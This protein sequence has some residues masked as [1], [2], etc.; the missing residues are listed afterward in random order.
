MKSSFRELQIGE[1]MPQIQIISQIKQKEDNSNKKQAK[2]QSQNQQNTKYFVNTEHQSYSKDI[3][4]VSRI[5]VK[6][7]Q[8]PTQI[9]DLRSGLNQSIKTSSK[10]TN[11]N[12]YSQNNQQNKQ[13]QEREKQSKKFQQSQKEQ[14][15]IL[16]RKKSSLKIQEQVQEDS[17]SQHTQNSSST[18]KLVQRFNSE[19]MTNN[20]EQPHSDVQQANS[21]TITNISNYNQQ[22]LEEE[23]EDDDEPD[24]GKKI[25]EEQKSGKRWKKRTTQSLVKNANRFYFQK[26]IKYLK[27]QFDLQ[28]NQNQNLA[29]NQNLDIRTIIQE[30]YQQAKIKPQSINLKFFRLCCMKLNNKNLEQINQK[31]D[32]Q[33]LHQTVFKNLWENQKIEKINAIKQELTIQISQYLKIFDFDKE[34]QEHSIQKQIEIQKRYRDWKDKI[35]INLNKLNAGQFNQDVLNEKLKSLQTQYNKY[36]ENYDVNS[37]TT[38]IEDS[39]AKSVKQYQA[40]SSFQIFEDADLPNVAENFREK[41][42]SQIFSDNTGT[43]LLSVIWWIL[44]FIIVLALYV[45]C[46]YSIFFK[47]QQRKKI[48]RQ[49]KFIIAGILFLLLSLITWQAI[50]QFNNE[51]D[52]SFDQTITN[53]DCTLLYNGIIFI[54]NEKKNQ[55]EWSGVSDYNTN[56]EALNDFYSKKITQSPYK[57]LDN[58][59]YNEIYG[60]LETQTENA[61]SLLT[62]NI[63]L[64]N[65]DP[66]ATTKP[67]IDSEYLLNLQKSV[68]PWLTIVSNYT[69]S[70]KTDG[71]QLGVIYTGLN[72]MLTN[73]DKILKEI[74]SAKAKVVQYTNSLVG[75]VSEFHQQLLQQKEEKQGLV[76]FV[77]WFFLISKL[78]VVFSGL[79]GFCLLMFVKG[80]DKIKIRIFGGNLM[81]FSWCYGIFFF[82][83]YIVVCVLGVYFLGVSIQTGY[84]QPL[85]ALENDSSFASKMWPG[86]KNQ[87]LKDILGEC[88]FGKDKN[89]GNV[90]TTLDTNNL[91]KEAQNVQKNMQI[92]TPYS[93]NLTVP[94]SA[95]INAFNT[96]KTNCN[97]ITSDFSKAIDSNGKN[98]TADVNAFNLWSDYNIKGSQQAGTGKCKVS[99]DQYTFTSCPANYTQYNNT[100]QLT[101]FSQKL[102]FVVNSEFPENLENIRYTDK[103]F[104]TCSTL[105]PQVFGEDS[106]SGVLQDYAH[107]FL[108]YTRDVE[109]KIVKN[110]PKINGIFNITTQ[111]QASNQARLS[112]KNITQAGAKS[113]ASD[114]ITPLNNMQNDLSCKFIRENL[115][116][117]T[118]NEVCYQAQNQIYSEYRSWI[119]FS[120]L[121]GLYLIAITFAAYQFFRLSTTVIV[122]K[123]DLNYMENSFASMEN[124]QYRVDTNQLQQQGE[125][126]QQQQQQQE[127]EIQQQHHQEENNYPQYVEQHD[128]QE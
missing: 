21:I 120:V 63:T 43:I 7:E 17:F 58:S 100:K 9:E 127:I 45:F 4:G 81:H 67:L 16:Q 125:I 88:A 50:V 82:L 108:I 111:V 54:K 116:E 56:L 42:Y 23:E 68:E 35:N 55:K 15:Q 20:L 40:V 62:K 41:N 70:L 105:K 34:I 47:R 102:C 106:V 115:I 96:H 99:Q 109:N 53:V 74:S 126:M 22:N 83:I 104:K 36:C 76:A 12:N 86:N 78:L 110:C 19:N 101:D 29:E 65:P 6:C 59:T 72:K 75:Q 3:N 90:F 10:N 92:Y 95:Q 124:S 8:E 30:T 114:Y 28:Q 66:S 91:L 57:E 61:K 113:F 37:R 118:R 5:Q 27:E 44:L 122:F 48:T 93:K 71:Q 51:T 2:I 80:E 73:K 69:D 87:E 52:E 94:T 39:T 117:P 11:L 31:K 46:I 98:A 84:C 85:S 103:A 24:K 119:L 89:L 33:I 97:A 26:I 107:N 123:N 1:Q 32:D 13:Q 49:E 79:I 64:S 121:F 38:S 112:A 60:D 14:I 128:E 25:Q 18:N 77:E